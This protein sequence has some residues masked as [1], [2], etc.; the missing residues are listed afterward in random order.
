MSNTPEKPTMTETGGDAL[1]AKSPADSFS[2]TLKTRSSTLSGSLQ[3]D[4]TPENPFLSLGVAQMLLGVLMA[5]FGVL[6]IVHD[7]SLASVG[8]GLWGG[9]VAMASGVVGLLAGLKS[10]YSVTHGMPSRLSVTAFL[11]LCL[12]SLAV[13]NLV[14]VLAVTGLV[15]D[16]Q[17]VEV[18]AIE[19]EKASA[20]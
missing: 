18:R 16:G 1:V 17:N 13:S 19:E 20:I 3:D 2:S 12:I 7:A 5:V 10:W 8:A 6:A 15:R 9:A 11:A 14:V 4:R